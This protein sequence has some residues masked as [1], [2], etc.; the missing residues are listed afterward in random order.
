M[1]PLAPVIIEPAQQSQCGLLTLSQV[2]QLALQALHLVKAGLQLGFF[3]SP[4]VAH[5]S[6]I[7]GLS[8]RA[9]IPSGPV[10]ERQFTQLDGPPARIA[11]I[12]QRHHLG[13]SHGPVCGA[14]MQEAQGQHFL[15]GPDLRLARLDGLQFSLQGDPACDEDAAFFLPGQGQ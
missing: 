1:H 10:Q 3:L 15:L 7:V 5:V 13:L 6:Q 2:G 11:L 8:H 14:K 4:A 9:L 12:P